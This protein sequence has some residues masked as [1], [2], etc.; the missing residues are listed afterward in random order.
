MDSNYGYIHERDLDAN[1]RAKINGIKTG[2]DVDMS[3]YVTKNDLSTE[4]SSIKNAVSNNINSLKQMIANTYYNKSDVI[5]KD[6]LYLAELD[7]KT[8]ANNIDATNK[9]IET[10]QKT[11]S[12]T[13]DTE[14]EKYMASH[15]SGSGNSGSGSTITQDQIT[16]INN[17]IALNQS[18]IA[19]NSQNIQKNTSSINTINDSLSEYR[20]TDTPIQLTDLS[21]ELQNKINKHGSGTSSDSTDIT[22]DTIG[23][24]YY[25][26]E[27]L[28]SSNILDTC[29]I[30]ETS[31]E[32]VE[33]Q[34]KWY[35]DIYDVTSNVVYKY[36]DSIVLWNDNYTTID[37]LY[38]DN[39]TVASGYKRV[40]FDATNYITNDS[41]VTV[42][43]S[44]VTLNTSDTFTLSFYGT[45]F[46][47]TGTVFA[48][49][50]NHL[51]SY[52][53]VMIDDNDDGLKIVPYS[54]FEG[55]TTDR[56]KRVLFGIENLSIGRHKIKL[57]VPSGSKL[58]LDAFI[59]IDDAN[60]VI[61]KKEDI[62][63][64]YSNCLF[65]KQDNWSTIPSSYGIT[66]S[67]DL[68]DLS[69]KTISD[70]YETTSDNITEIDK[71]SEK[72]LYSIPTKDVYTISNHK[73]YKIS[74]NIANLI[75]T[76]DGSYVK[77]ANTVGQNIK[78]LDKTI[79]TL[80]QSVSSNT[81]NVNSL[82]GKVP[83]LTA[84]GTYIKKANT[85]TANLSALDTQVKKNAA[86]LP[87]GII[88]LYNGTTV[89][90]GWLACDGKNGTPDLS[91]VKVNNIGY[92]MK[93]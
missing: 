45:K 73:L 35:N 23:P 82:S 36:K 18:N 75:S 34:K 24:V 52:V 65:D 79:S 72:I 70:I 3:Q 92:I 53:Y 58:I 50:K 86:A 28:S 69:S 48:Y 29:N 62:L 80:S 4:S 93:K 37:N 64:D 90:D 8:N 88:M 83:D 26:G 51:K 40:T 76:E 22:C 38:A 84:D 1:V 85:I 55:N 61:L 57:T 77:K 46:K 42:A 59:D 54:T 68:F 10:L 7:I 44:T 67:T 2:T 20:R 27:S 12:S 16:A 41:S 21:T 25:D 78:L 81:S 60:S 11:M 39:T 71:Y 13:I 17:N 49:D 5:S 89:P 43:N 32:V 66:K 63:S 9:K 74:D 19:V 87:S 30:C 56:T 15:S 6:S 33:A 91:T 31:E 47:L 14:I